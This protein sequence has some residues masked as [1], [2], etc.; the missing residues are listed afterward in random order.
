MIFFKLFLFLLPLFTFAHEL[1]Y[2]ADSEGGAPYIFQDPQ[3]P[4]RTIGFEVELAEFISKKLGLK[5]VHVQNQWDGLILGLKR[6]NYDLAMNGLEITPERK[7][8]VAFSD[9]YYMTFTALTVRGEEQS[10][11]TLADCRGKKVGTLKASLAEEILK[12]TGGIEIASYEADLNAFEDLANGRIHAVLLDYP[13]SVY[14]GKPN[15]RLK[16]LS[17]PIGKIEYGIAVRKGD[18]SLLKKV[19]QALQELRQEGTLAELY[20]RWGLWE[21]ELARFLGENATPQVPASAYE[22]FVSATAPE[23][24]FKDRLR[25]YWSYLPLLVRG[26]MTTLELSV[27]GMMLAMALGL[28]LAVLRIYAPAPLSQLSVLVIEVVRGTPLLIQL[29]IIFYGLPNLGIRLE[30]F[31]AAI[32]GL[33]LNYAAYEAENY[34]AGIAAVPSGQLDAALA[35]GMT[36]SQAFLHVTL[37][38]AVRLIIPPVTNDFIALIKDSSLVSVITMVELTKVY[39][40]LA[41]THYDYLGIG[42]LAALM[43]FL[44]GLPFVRLA[45]MMEK[46]LGWGQVGLRAKAR[47]DQAKKAAVGSV[48]V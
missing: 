32:L 7:K 19:N 38:Q 10:I 37:P 11:R 44:V 5:P 1:R 48:P 25:Q 4:S 15:P 46:R 17:T 21:P 14:R 24:S 20:Q 40:Q 13:I 22:D 18:Q 43:Y 34:R 47:F 9:P 23:P 12:E 2:G 27:L 29:Y 45:R 36:R 6:G 41:A 8:E 35:L 16:V 30:P 26:A 28:V 33:G 31:W 3:D 39:G 42:L